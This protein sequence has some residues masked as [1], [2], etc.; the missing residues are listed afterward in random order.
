[1]SESMSET[2]PDSHKLLEEE[3]AR[4]SE[5]ERVSR[6]KDEFLATLGHE[7]RAPLN[8]I[9]GWSRLLESGRL[10]AAEARHGGQI[11][12]RNVRS[13]AQL[14]DDLLDMTGIVSGK[15]RMD[16]EETDLAEIVKAVL[17]NMQAT[18]DEKG[19]ILQKEL[20][21]SACLVF[22]DPHRLQQAIWNLLSNAVKFTARGGTVTT[23]LKCADGDWEVRISD[24]GIGF[25]PEVVPTLFD[26]FRPPDRS[27]RRGHQ[28]L[29]IGLSIVKQLVELHGGR[30][31]GAS[32]G[33]GRGATFHVSLPRV[34]PREYVE[35]TGANRITRFDLEGVRVLVVDDE[36]DTLELSRQVLGGY[37][38]QVETAASTDAAL[39]TLD[40]FRANVLVSDLSMPGRDGYDLIRAVR[41]NQSAESLPAAALTAFARPEDAV[42]AHD[43]GFQMHLAKPVEPEELARIVAQ[44]AGRA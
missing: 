43:A 27:I 19:L 7:L 15:I 39:A 31:S 28:G 1:M 12:A 16:L 35:I 20:P 9:L 26:R 22:G 34:A 6:L 18:A 30:V 3:R 11:I 41:I 5:A 37:H 17:E 8:A 10:G 32:A 36:L 21:A 25:E 13:L 4:R 33:A 29:G 42:R 38:A 14:V 24:T 2:D 44:L 40:A 23:S